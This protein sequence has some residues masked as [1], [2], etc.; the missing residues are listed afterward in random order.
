[1][2]SIVGAPHTRYSARRAAALMG[3]RSR[4]ASGI[5]VPVTQRTDWSAGRDFGAE[6]AQCG[7]L[8][9]LAK[10]DEV[11]ALRNAVK[12]KGTVSPTQPV[13]TPQ[14]LNAVIKA[15]M[16]DWQVNE[17]DSSG[18]P[19]LLSNRP[20]GRWLKLTKDQTEKVETDPRQ[21]FYLP[22]KS[23][24]ERV[25]NHGTYR[26][27]VGELPSDRPV[28]KLSLYRENTSW[29]AIMNRV[30]HRTRV[31]R[32]ALDAASSKE[33]FGC[34]SQW[35]S[36]INVPRE[37]LNHAN[38]HYNLHAILFDPKLHGG[39]DQ[40]VDSCAGNAW[41]VLLRCVT[42]AQED[43]D[44]SLERIRDRGFVNYFPLSTFGATANFAHEVVGAAARG[45]Y[46][47]ACRLWLQ[48]EAERNPVL[49]GSY[50]KY[51]N[52][53][54]GSEA[55]ALDTMLQEL[56]NYRMKR[57]LAPFVTLLRDATKRGELEGRSR[58]LWTSLAPYDR[59]SLLSA[60]PAF[61]WNAMASQRLLSYGT[62]VVEGDVV[63]AN[64]RQPGAPVKP[65]LVCAG[66]ASAF[67]VE[68]VLLPLPPAGTSANRNKPAVVFPATV[69]V[70]EQLYR[71]MVEDHRLQAAIDAWH[72]DAVKSAA[73]YRFLVSRPKRLKWTIV[74]D[75]D[76]LS[77]L[78]TDRFIREE[79]RP[80]GLELQSDRLRPPSELN[81]P[82]AFRE[83]LQPILHDSRSGT[84]SVALTFELAAGA[85]PTAMLLESFNVRQACFHDLLTP[86]PLDGMR[87]ETRP[88]PVPKAAASGMRSRSSSK[89]KRG[90]R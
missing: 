29:D 7:M 62:A 54:Q 36:A 85:H 72:R 60:A 11:V 49:H 15:D 4:T 50:L 57:R 37:L 43:I 42:G 53:R 61:V 46:L 19:V 78:K 24:Q 64:R 90:S 44:A 41:R 8:A 10:A 18:L 32:N 51:V 34:V 5:N 26:P 82:P 52:A 83:M 77:L 39:V 21:E 38:R 47:D 28:L 74:Q 23:F 30:E 2:W 45:E 20:K 80:V 22:H 35:I 13:A 3:S 9:T 79:R 66:E 1:M 59:D 70:N 71:R 58:Q 16:G 69:V 63:D 56:S 75:P 67:T 31:S 68:D 25:V 81:L 89:P 17:I 48:C 55:A 6:E 73:P 84:S 76:S 27:I 86:T 14:R 87:A 88:V 65:H 33:A 40:I 12:N